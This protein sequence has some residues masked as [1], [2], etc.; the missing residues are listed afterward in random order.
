MKLLGIALKWLLLVPGIAQAGL[1][2][3][4]PDGKTKLDIL[5]S[6]NGSS[7][8]ARSAEASDFYKAN[9]GLNI[10][11]FESLLDEN[12]IPVTENKDEGAIFAVGAPKSGTD[13]AW[14][15]EFTILNR[16]TGAAKSVI[17]DLKGQAF[18][19]DL[20][21]AWTDSLE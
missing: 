16:E 8:I 1:D 20:K 4:S 7:V 6:L 2:C 10:S 12:Q 5:T 9:Y 19:S 17:T 18:A 21:C 11:T 3:S 15:I 14:S 13:A